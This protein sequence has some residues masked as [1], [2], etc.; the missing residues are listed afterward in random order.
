MEVLPKLSILIYLKNTKF[1]QFSKKKRYRLI[2]LLSCKIFFCF[3]LLV[4]LYMLPSWVCPR[5]K[6]KIL[7]ISPKIPLVI[8]ASSLYHCVGVLWT[9]IV[10]SR[11]SD[12]WMD[13][14][15]LWRVVK[16]AKL[17]SCSQSLGT[18]TPPS[19]HTAKPALPVKSHKHCGRVPPVTRDEMSPSHELYIAF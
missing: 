2:E 13:W 8:F 16:S 7:V 14:R 19:N 10:T 18:L 15:T 12:A 6:Y 11:H 3:F 5:I 4:F 17:L 1:Y 9:R